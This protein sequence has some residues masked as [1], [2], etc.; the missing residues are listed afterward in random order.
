M[1]TEIHSLMQHANHI[2]K[3]ITRNVEND[4]PA[5]GIASI[6]LASLIT[7]TPRVGILRNMLHR[8]SNFAHVSL[9]LKN[10]PTNLG[11]IPY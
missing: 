4:M 11:E 7:T 8:H 5:D 1:S 10:T 9:S 6:S 3:F 2:D